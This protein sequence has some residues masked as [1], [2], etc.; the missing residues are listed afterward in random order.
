MRTSDSHPIEV[1]WLPYLNIG[2][3]FCP[4]KKQ[5]NS[6]TGGWD[7]DIDKD[8]DRLKGYYGVDR[9]I[10]L[11][12]SEELEEYGIPNY[13]AKIEEHGMHWIH[14]PFPNDTCPPDASAFVSIG[15]YLN[16]EKIT[17]VIHCKG[18]IG[19]TAMLAAVCLSFNK[20]ICIE[21]ALEEISEIRQ[22]ILTPEQ[23]KWMLNNFM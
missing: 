10:C 7:R 17:T 18:G 2:L 3:T 6:M 11:M 19:R 12:E 13:F 23:R 4:G 15:R 22:V 1:S 21:K 20:H 9:I 5:T 8:L 16:L 14:L